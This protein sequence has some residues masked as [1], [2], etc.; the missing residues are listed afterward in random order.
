MLVCVR[1]YVLVRA[2]CVCVLVC[3]CVCALAR[4]RA[5]GVRVCVCVL[6]AC[7][8]NISQYRLTDVQGIRPSHCQGLTRKVSSSASVYLIGVRCVWLW[9]GGRRNQPK[10]QE[11]EAGLPPTPLITSFDRN[12]TPITIVTHGQTGFLWSTGLF[13]TNL[14]L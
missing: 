5:L 4:V 10:P 3:A 6:L 14:S 2:A 12:W 11:S 13:C 9:G 8:H 7:M 1:T